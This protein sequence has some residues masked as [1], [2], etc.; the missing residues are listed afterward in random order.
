VRGRDAAFADSLIVA[1]GGAG[2]VVV[3]LEGDV[4]GLQP[5]GLA[6]DLR[7][8]D[9]GSDVALANSRHPRVGGA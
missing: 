3:E 1:E 5:G 7:R 8:V 9:S 4:G 2:E 6:F